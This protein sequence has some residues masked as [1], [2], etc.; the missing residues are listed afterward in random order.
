[1][2]HRYLIGSNHRFL[3]KISL[4]FLATDPARERE[5]ERERTC[6]LAGRGHRTTE[7][8][9][10][11]QGRGLP[12]TELRTMQRERDRGGLLEKDAG[13]REGSRREGRGLPATELPT[14]QRERERERDRGGLPVGGTPDA[15][16]DGTVWQRNFRERGSSVGGEMKFHIP[17]QPV[18]KLF[19]KK[20]EKPK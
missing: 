6:F 10:R 4:F 18:L 12:A 20:N 9:D 8:A 14:M 7:E 19:K 15:E 16:R 1:M 5:R 11:R 2:G 3:L 13:R 17:L